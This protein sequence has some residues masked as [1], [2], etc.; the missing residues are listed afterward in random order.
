MA[1]AQ[2]T[3]IRWRVGWASS[4]TC[5]PTRKI[6]DPIVTIWSTPKKSSTDEWSVRS[7]SRSY[8]PCSLARITQSGRLAQNSTS[9]HCGTTVSTVVDVGT[10]R[11]CDDERS[12]EPDHVR[13]EQ[14][15]PHQPAAARTPCRRSSAAQSRQTPLQP[16]V[17]QHSRSPPPNYC[18]PP[19]RPTRERLAVDVPF[20][21]SSRY[22]EGAGPPT[23]SDGS[24]LSAETGLTFSGRA[25]RSPTVSERG[26]PPCEGL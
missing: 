2:N 17:R 20:P 7:S 9:S 15:P 16:P 14:Q 11:C 4:M 19:T 12:H 6:Q 25:R 24:S 18:S 21:R 13:Q 3:T 1:S 8:S 10:S 23:S 22:S 5:V 26:G